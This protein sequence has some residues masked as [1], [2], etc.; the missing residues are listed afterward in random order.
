VLDQI[1][2]KVCI[3]TVYQ[4]TFLYSRPNFPRHTSTDLSGKALYEY[5]SIRKKADIFKVP[6]LSQFI[7]GLSRK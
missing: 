7:Q 5:F 1:C 4:E 2:N 3:A 6:E